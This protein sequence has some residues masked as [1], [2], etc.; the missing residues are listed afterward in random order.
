[1]LSLRSSP[2]FH[3]AHPSALTPTILTGLV[4]LSTSSAAWAAG[5][6]KWPAD[7]TVV[8]SKPDETVEV[9]GDLSKGKPMDLDF[10]QKSS[11]ACF[12]A[13]AFDHYRGNHVLF[14]THLP[15]RS[16]MNIT[17]TP[18][19]KDADINVY[20]YSIG[21]TNF[22]VPPGLASCVSCEA[23]PSSNIPA[24]VG[25]AEAV[26]LNS[27]NNPY[28]VVIGVAGAKGR[29]AGAFTLKVELKTKK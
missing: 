26:S 17:V 20:A 12:V 8:E 24:K 2:P 18:A 4:A 29:V 22:S 6:Q 3:S 14:A 15:K 28:N 23:S 11:N 13:P 7:V 5:E 9:A 10:A 1:M 19:D 27:V 25:T 21:A 16:V